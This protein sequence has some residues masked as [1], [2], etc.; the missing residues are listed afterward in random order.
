[1]VDQPQEHPFVELSPSQSSP[2]PVSLHHAQAD[3]D[4]IDEPSI[5]STSPV[6]TADTTASSP[7]SPLTEVTSNTAASPAASPTPSA[8]ASPEASPK[9]SPKASTSLIPAEPLLEVSQP[10]I[11]SSSPLDVKQITHESPLFDEI[12]LFDERN[13]QKLSKKSTMSRFPSISREEVISDHKS[14]SRHSSERHS[15][16]VVGTSARPTDEAFLNPVKL[17]SQMVATE[18]R[19]SLDAQFDELKSTPSAVAMSEDSTASPEPPVSSLRSPLFGTE[20]ASPSLSV[21]RI[22]GSQ[23]L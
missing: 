2:T 3:C 1:V 10:T 17:P 13:E 20:V 18:L 7:P 14:S 22:S 16:N 12:P 19:T 23:S 11:T 15:T 4:V 5:P 8:G 21:S 9:A 6:K